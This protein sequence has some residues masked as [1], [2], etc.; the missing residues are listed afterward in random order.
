M[1]RG[2]AQKVMGVL[3]LGVLVLFVG[4][5]SSSAA[6]PD[7]HVLAGPVSADVHAPASEEAEAFRGHCHPGLDCFVTAVFI[8]PAAVNPP[9]LRSSVTHINRARVLTSLP[10]TFDPPPPR[11][12][13]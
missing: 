13:S 3:L 5:P 6:H 9:S 8:L 2:L 12:V 4:L 10:M 1:N 11:R 7:D